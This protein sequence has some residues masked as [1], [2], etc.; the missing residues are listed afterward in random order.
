MNQAI[1]ENRGESKYYATTNDYAFV[2][3]T[4]GQGANPIDTLLASLAA[5]VA[6]HVIYGLRDAAIENSGFSVRASAEL[7]EDRQRLAAISVVTDMK[8]I[9][10][11]EAQCEVL[12]SYAQRCPIYN[13]LKA[14]CPISLAWAGQG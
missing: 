8:Q 13:T 5:C 14:G 9:A 7:T 6:H 3:D 1:V 10:I 4:R 12:A 11:D 2:M